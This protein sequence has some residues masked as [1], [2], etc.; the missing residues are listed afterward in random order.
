MGY[1]VCEFFFI[2]EKELKLYIENINENEK[3]VNK[4]GDYV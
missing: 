1:D 2:C 3:C 4:N